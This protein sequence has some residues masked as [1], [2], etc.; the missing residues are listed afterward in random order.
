MVRV[1]QPAV[2]VMRLGSDRFITRRQ[3]VA[4]FDIR[5]EGSRRQEE[6]LSNV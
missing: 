1:I 2:L 5:K 6:L 4:S 3:V